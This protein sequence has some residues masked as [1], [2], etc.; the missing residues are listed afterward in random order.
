MFPCGIWEQPVT[1]CCAGVAC[2]DCK[3]WYHET[4][5]DM[6]FK[7]FE[8]LNRSNVNWLCCKCDRINCNSFTFHSYELECSNYYSLIA[9]ISIDSLSSAFS[10][11]KTSNPGAG[12]RPTSN[13]S[14]NRIPSQTSHTPSART[15]SLYRLPTKQNLRI[16]TLNCRSVADKRCCEEKMKKLL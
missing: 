10:P 12:S 3:I 8:V 4:C 16:L 7:Y 2:D 6:C 14:R 1:W 13:T 11:L 5:T 15:K 9:D